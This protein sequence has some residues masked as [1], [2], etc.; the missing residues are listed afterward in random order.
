MKPRNTKGKNRKYKKSGTKGV[1]SSCMMIEDAEAENTI[2][3]YNRN[4]KVRKKR[5]RVLRRII[6]FC[7]RCI[8]VGLT[9]FVFL[10][11]GKLYEAVTESIAL[12]DGQSA[13]SLGLSASTDYPES[14][15]DLAARNS[16]A[17]EFVKKYP[18]NKDKEFT[19][20]LSKEVEKGSIPLFLQWDERWGYEVYGDDFLAVTG[21]GPTCLSM[22]RCGLSGDTKW[23]PLEVARFA[24]KKGYYVNDVG[25][26]WV[27]MSEGAEELG[28]SVET[29][30]F[31]ASHILE[32]LEAGNPIICTMRPGDFTTTGHYIVLTGVDNEGMVTVCD[33]NS[34]KNS[35]K[36]WDVEMLIPQIKNLWSYT[37]SG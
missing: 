10:L 31:D 37:Y 21:C 23:N 9:I 1:A 11:A 34:R 33:P 20:D 27:L 26:S 14:L 24:D 6:L 7:C 8:C 16:E 2:Q 3:N 30:F 36:S 35:E 13:I 18:Q 25:S 28:L 17:K 19:I 5:K 29:V 32:E 12:E 4:K 22:V 15:L